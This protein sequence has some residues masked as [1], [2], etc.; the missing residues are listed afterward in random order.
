MRFASGH[1]YTVNYNFSVMV[2]SLQLA[3][4]PQDSDSVTVYKE[5]LLVVADFLTLEQDSLDSIYVKVARDQETFGWIPES[6]L[7]DAVAPDDP[8]SQFIYLFSHTHLRWFLLLIGLAILNYLYR[9]S[10]RKP[11]LIVYFNDIDSPYPALFCLFVAISATFYGSIQHF[12]P[13]TW[14]QYYYNPSLNPFEL[15]L[16]LACFITCFWI[17][18]ILLIAVIDEVFRKLPVKDAL[19][20]LVGMAAICV[21]CYIFF[22]FTTAYYIGYLFLACYI[23]FALFRSLSFSRYQC[24][25]CG[26]RLRRRTEKCPHCGMQNF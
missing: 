6:R 7:L 20:Y 15:P 24:G 8:I 2:D 10:L 26:H 11:L 18:V 16:G 17:L 12:V 13:E 25:N 5:D 3:T 4:E 9:V 22:T 19:T 14:V 23:A 21:V 1:H